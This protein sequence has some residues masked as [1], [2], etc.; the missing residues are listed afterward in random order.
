MSS[1]SAGLSNLCRSKSSPPCTQQ[2]S[3][4]IAMTQA[5]QAPVAR[6]QSFILGY[7]THRD[8]H[9]RKANGCAHKRRSKRTRSSPKSSLLSKA[10][11]IPT[12][13]RSNTARVA[14]TEETGAELLA[15]L[16]PTPTFVPTSLFAGTLENSV[17]IS[18]N[19]LQCLLGGER[20][21]GANASGPTVASPPQSP[22]ICHNPDITTSEG[23]ESGGVSFWGSPAPGKHSRLR[24]LFKRPGLP[25]GYVGASTT[26]SGGPSNLTNLGNASVSRHK[27]R[28][29]W[30]TDANHRH[31]PP[32]IRGETPTSP[33]LRPAATPAPL[34][35]P[36]RKG[37][38]LNWIRAAVP[39]TSSL[40]P[41]IGSSSDSMPM[42]QAKIKG[43]RLG[44]VVCKLQSLL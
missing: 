25:E 12:A 26:L 24:R 16:S 11:G 36:K 30:F 23:C 39:A 38:N 43:G 27:S 15:S 10:S 7:S 8:V 19:P 2:S 5:A 41:S 32:S 35:S 31:R 37:L 1:C 3:S 22:S 42:P 29:L 6:A 9:T 34:K 28:R 21:P 4:L 17:V 33:I 40:K 44:A 18:S 13:L 14:S 20:Q